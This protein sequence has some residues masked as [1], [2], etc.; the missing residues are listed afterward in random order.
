MGVGAADAE[1]GDGRT[2]GAAGV[3]PVEWFGEY[4]DRAGRPV[5]VRGRLVHVQGLGQDALAHGH[6]HLDHAGRARGRAR[7]TEVGLERPDAQ[8]PF[9]GTPLSVRRQERFGLDRVAERGAGAVRFNGVHVGRGQ[10]RVLQSLA[11]D[12]LLRQAVRRR[13][14]VAGAVLVDGRAPYERQ[15]AVSVAARVRQPL[16]DQYRH[17]LGPV[18]AVGGGG[19]GLA[20]AVQRQR[21]LAELRERARSGHHHHTAGQGQRALARPQRLGGEVQRDQ[22]RGAGRIDRDRRTLQTE[23]VRDTARDDRGHVSGR[24][25]SLGALGNLVRG[26]E[27]ARRGRSGEHAGGRPPLRGRIDSRPLERLP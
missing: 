18:G 19:E 12:P 26:R 25:E 4:R 11:D 10:V 5:D 23:R 20:A 17:A 24:H 16:H 13:D 6:D 27:I 7:V 14:P 22:G 2:A 1:G 15:D 9:G 3:G 21:P 8:G